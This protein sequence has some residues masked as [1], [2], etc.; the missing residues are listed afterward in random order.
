M[1]DELIKTAEKKLRG[2]MHNISKEQLTK[3]AQEL[4]AFGSIEIPGT[5]GG[6]VTL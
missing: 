5:L 3:L 2:V 6:V 1:Q 4:V